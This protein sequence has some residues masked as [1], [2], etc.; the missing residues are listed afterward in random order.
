LADDILASVDQCEAPSRE[1]SYAES[2]AKSLRLVAFGDREAFEEVYQRTS[3][4]LFGVCLT[5]LPRRSDAEDALQDTYS[6]VWRSAALF[7]AQ[8]GTAMTWLITLA[9]NRAVD[10]VRR[11]RPSIMAPIEW[12]SDVVDPKPLAFATIASDQQH[13]KMYRCLSLLSERDSD[14]LKMAFFAG[15]TYADL[16]IAACIPVGT[17]KSRVR[18]ALMR[19]RAGMA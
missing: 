18:R 6:N 16:A 17:M 8:R 10:Q 19:L 12:A 1:T 13:R 15:E 4:K 5:I 3:A 7:D 2:L 11:S 14:A 9:R